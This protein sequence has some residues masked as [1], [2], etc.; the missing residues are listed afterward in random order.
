MYNQLREI[1]LFSIKKAELK[2]FRMNL[3]TYQILQTARRNLFF[4]A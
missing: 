3:C 1:N 2:Y 4:E